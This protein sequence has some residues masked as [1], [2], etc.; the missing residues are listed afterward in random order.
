MIQL[1][2]LPHHSE[3]VSRRFTNFF[4][5]STGTLPLIKSQKVVI[6]A[7]SLPLSLQGVKKSHFH[8]HR[9]AELTA[10]ALS[11]PH[12]GGGNFFFYFNIFNLSPRGRG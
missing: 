4:K 2:S 11:L 3:K 7:L 9:S 1:K 12:R 10:E 6:S 5:L 8:P